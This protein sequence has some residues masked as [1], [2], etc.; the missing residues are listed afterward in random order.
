MPFWS[1]LRS[2]RSRRTTTR[3]SRRRRPLRL[4]ALEDRCLLSVASHTPIAQQI[5]ATVAAGQRLPA[6]N[7]NVVID[8][9]A[10]MLEA[11]WTDATAPTVASRT[12]AMVQ[13]AVYDA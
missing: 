4:E 10:T 5:A 11:V 8:W 7:D 12:M 6:R 13:V 2:G 9:N 3:Q 1:S